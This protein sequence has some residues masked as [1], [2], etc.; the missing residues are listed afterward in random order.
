MFPT[1]SPTSPLPY[2]SISLNSGYTLLGAKDKNPQSLPPNLS[3]LIY[4]HFTTLGI[5]L[6]ESQTLKLSRWA[7]LNLPN[8]QIARS[9]WKEKEK[10]SDKLRQARNIKVMSHL[11]SSDIPAI[12]ETVLVPFQKH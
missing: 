12:T 6:P 9:L 8:G 7:R 2:G 11:I 4:N 3:H 10:S 1:L 5:V